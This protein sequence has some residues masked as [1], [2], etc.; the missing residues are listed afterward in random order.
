MHS[1]YLD[2][3]KT[4]EGFASQASWD[5]RQHTNGYGTRALHPGEAIS[6][7]EADRR[8][9]EEISAARRLVE[10][11]AGAWD[12]GTK[13][14]LTSLTFNAG[15]RWTSDGLGDAVRRHDVEAVR[16]RF[17]QYT[18]AGGVD[19]PGLVRRRL[20]ELAWIGNPPAAA[21]MQVARLPEDLEPRAADGVERGT[22]DWHVAP[23]SGDQ[24]QGTALLPPARSVTTETTAAP[25]PSDA[26]AGLLYWTLLR[27]V[28]FDLRADAGTKARDPSD[29]AGPA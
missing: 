21:P 9:A 10:K 14:A 8:F 24:V 19:L 4:L 3:I 15:S 28:L 12:E 6:R 7:A 22:P 17:L 1:I 20:V 27:E 29:G 13:A 26:R 18:K 16:E 2:E 11:H 25:S 23:A 5:Y